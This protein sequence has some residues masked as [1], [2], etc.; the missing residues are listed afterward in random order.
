MKIS[1]KVLADSINAEGVRIMSFEL[2][3]HRYVL[4]ELN[5]HRD[6]TRNGASSRAIPTAKLVEQ[7]IIERVEPLEWGLNEG[8]MQ[9]FTVA[10]DALRQKGQRV[11]DD[12]RWNAIESARKLTELGF[13]KQIVNRVLE[14]FLPT[15]TVLTTTNL[16]NFEALRFHKDAQPEIRELARCVIEAK[17]ASSPKVLK[18]GEWH[19]P[20]ILA[21]D[22]ERTDALLRADPGFADAVKNLLTPLYGVWFDNDDDLILNMVSAA[23]AARA[24]YRLV[25]GSQTPFLKDLELFQRLVRDQ[26]VHASPT[27][28]QA[29]PAGI[30]GKNQHTGNFRSWAQ[31]RKLIKGET[32]HDA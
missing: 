15:R 32:V 29:T 24:S 2:Y 27:E 1:A 8:G 7:C 10:D 31:F 13:A 25:D 19:R 11:W 21:E 16:A 12:A 18:V 3:Y 28:H 30:E 23:R 17:E 9:A 22:Y 4:A 20:Y 26:P 5:T 6:F 14:P